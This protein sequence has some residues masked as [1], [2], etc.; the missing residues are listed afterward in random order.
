MTE[1][2]SG[3]DGP[4]IE[5]MRHMLTRPVGVDF[6]PLVSRHYR[7]LLCG[8]EKAEWWRVTKRTKVCSTCIEGSNSLRLGSFPKS[9][10]SH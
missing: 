6:H 5:E 1:K 10:Q 9:Q 8:A 4:A 3:R 2:D 7:C